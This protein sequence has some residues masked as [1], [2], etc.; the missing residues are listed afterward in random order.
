MNHPT[1]TLI[2]AG[3][4][5]LTTAIALRQKGFQVEI[6]ESFPEFKD[7]GAGIIL[8]NNAMQVFDRLG[9]TD[10]LQA[11]SSSLDR[12]KITDHR[13]KVISEA[14]TQTGTSN[15]LR[16]IAIHRSALQRV[17][18]DQLPADCLHLGK[19]LEKID[20]TGDSPLLIF[21]DGTSHQAEVVIGAD[22]IHSK[23]RDAVVANSS[24]RDAKQLC[25][26]GVAEMELPSGIKGMF[27][28]MWGK[29]ARIG[30][31]EIREGVVYWFAV[32]DQQEKT[33][34]SQA[35]ILALF[36][37]FHPIA[38][39]IISATESSKI[40]T[41][42]LSDLVPLPFWH[43]ANICLIGDAAHATTP[44]MGQGACQAIEDALALSEA[45]ARERDLPTAFAAFEQRRMKKA[46]KIVSTSWQIG[47]MAH[48]QNGLGIFLRNTLMRSIPTKL[49]VKQNAWVYR[50]E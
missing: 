1:F 46:N 43:T 49:L 2:G 36:D 31:G 18:L 34:Y 25:W 28:E 45:V 16:S 35:E 7:L 5:G 22:G 9:L 26:R 37:G 12:M 11:V 47:K 29:K 41:N 42:G 6:F 21:A 38:Q 8:A 17:L 4:S 14:S 10:Q 24:I 39:E 27:H 48:M 15:D 3:I 20:T 13:F 33:Q 30:F 50:T 19:R 32:I 40:L 23:V 44:N